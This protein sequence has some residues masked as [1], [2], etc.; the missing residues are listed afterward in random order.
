MVSNKLFLGSLGRQS[1]FAFCKV[2]SRHPP[3]ENPTH[4]TVEKTFLVQSKSGRK[5]LEDFTVFFYVQWMETDYDALFL[6]RTRKT[7][8]SQ[9]LSHSFPAHLN[10]FRRVVLSFK[11]H[12][13]LTF[14][15]LAA[16]N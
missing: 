12:A 1:I 10:Y 5:N 4:A 8:P 15:D 9:E 2:D 6:R 13:Q 16:I 3:S 14:R 11:M 7:S